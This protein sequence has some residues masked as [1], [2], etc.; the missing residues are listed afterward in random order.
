MRKLKAF[1]K[2]NN[3]PIVTFIRY[4]KDAS[5]SELIVDLFFPVLLAVVLLY[6]TSLTT[7]KLSMLI[8]K[9]QQVSGLST[10]NENSPLSALEFSPL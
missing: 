1:Y 2:A 6:F 7:D 8:G 10:A 9:F 3:F 5:T 4:W